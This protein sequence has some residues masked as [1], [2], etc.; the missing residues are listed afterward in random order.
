MQPTQPPAR[1]WRSHPIGTGSITVNAVDVPPGRYRARFAGQ[2]Y[3]V[4]HGAERLRIE[5]WP[6][7][8]DA[9]PR[10]RRTWP[11]W[12]PQPSSGGLTPG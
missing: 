1:A 12:D 2:G 5:L 9:P 7:S 10:A 3:R 11:G 4:A 8:T 6:R